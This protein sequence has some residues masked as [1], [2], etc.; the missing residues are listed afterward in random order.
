MVHNKDKG[1]ISLRHFSVSTRPS[2]LT[3]GVKALVLGKKLPDMS[4]FTDVAD[5]VER[6]GFASESEGEDAEA[7]RVTLRQHLGRHNIAHRTS[8]VRLHEVCTCSDLPAVLDH[9]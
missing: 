8:R 1:T 4:S 5:F 7:S 3:K 2:G 9:L 6:A